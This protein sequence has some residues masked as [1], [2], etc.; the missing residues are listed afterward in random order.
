MDERYA[1]ALTHERERRKRQ[2]DRWLR[3]KV[4]N[5]PL[6]WIFDSKLD[7]IYR[8]QVRETAQKYRRMKIRYFFSW[9]GLSKFFLAPVFK[10]G[11][12]S[13]LVTPFIASIYISL[14]STFG[15]LFNYRFPEQMGLLFF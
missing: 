12:T 2:R 5:L 1:K 10:V 14:L 4:D 11:L 15:S 13:I 3:E 6:F 8:I 9:E 7:E